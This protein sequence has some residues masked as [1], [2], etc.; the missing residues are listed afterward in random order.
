LGYGFNGTG[1]C[2]DCPA[3][4]FCTAGKITGDCAPGYVCLQKAN[5]HTPSLQDDND[6]NVDAYPCPLG[7][8]CEEGT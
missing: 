7:Y 2:T 1:N 6:N 4:E 5:Q 3:G 8:Y